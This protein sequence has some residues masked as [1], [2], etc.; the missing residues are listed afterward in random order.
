MV[1]C[2]LVLTV[3]QQQAGLDCLTILI[4]L[5]ACALAPTSSAYG[6]FQSNGA[7]MQLTDVLVDRLEMHANDRLVLLIA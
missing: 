1:I 7:V 6:A 4:V 3:H 5:V 2:A